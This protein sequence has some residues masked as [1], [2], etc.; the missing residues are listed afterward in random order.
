M[1]A[2]NKKRAGTSQITCGLS[3]REMRVSSWFTADRHALVGGSSRVTVIK[4]SLCQNPFPSGLIDVG[5]HRHESIRYICTCS[6]DRTLATP[7]ALT[8]V[9]HG[10][11]DVPTDE[12]APSSRLR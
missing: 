6:R 2:K 8:M 9:V 3:S 12:K 4:V 5:Y 1:S 11:L 7:Q 10:W